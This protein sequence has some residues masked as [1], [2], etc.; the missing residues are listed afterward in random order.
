MREQVPEPAVQESGAGASTASGCQELG[1]RAG[2]GAGTRYRHRERHMRRILHSIPCWSAYDATSTACWPPHHHQQDAFEGPDHDNH[3]EDVQRRSV[4]TARSPVTASLAPVS[5]M[6][7]SRETAVV[8]G[9]PVVQEMMVQAQVVAREVEGAS[10]GLGETVEVATLIPR[11]RVQQQTAEHIVDEP[12]PQIK[13]EIV[14]VV[15]IVPQ[16]RIWRIS[17]QIV[18][19]EVPKI[20]SQDRILQRTVEQI[21][22]ESV[23]VQQRIDKPI[24]E[25]LIPHVM[26]DCVEESKIAP[27][28][29][30]F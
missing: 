12:V 21:L 2:T 20:S 11:E 28:V 8:Q 17:E 1:T 15:H 9:A 16:E 29:F 18:V 25:L 7:V 24:V 3:D 13:V 22:D 10:Q 4:T 19:I 23:V 6:A 30:F 14:E 5:A 27:Q 26:E